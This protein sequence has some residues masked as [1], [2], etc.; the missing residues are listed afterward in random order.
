MA[1]DTGIEVLQEKLDE[2]EAQ[3]QDKASDYTQFVQLSTQLEELQTTSNILK[4]K[5]DTEMS[6][7]RNL[8]VS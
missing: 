3:A 1:L 2:S 4:A 6:T 7:L 5:H 8:R